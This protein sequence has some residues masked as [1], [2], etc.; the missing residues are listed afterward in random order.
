MNKQPIRKLSG[1]GHGHDTP[2][3]THD[4][5]DAHAHEHVPLKPY[6]VKH[7]HTYGETAHPFGIGPEGYKLE[8]WEYMFYGTLI[9]CTL[10][11]SVGRYARPDDSIQNWARREAL[12]REKH[13]ENGGE[14]EFGVYYQ[15]P[16]YEL[17]ADDEHQMPTVVEE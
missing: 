1:G 6:E 5:H 17:S 10:M 7:K 8:G 2:H 9:I 16:K 13:K 11:L 14:V 12:A 15:L 3:K 4:A